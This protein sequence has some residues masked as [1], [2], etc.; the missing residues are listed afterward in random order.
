MK[1]VFMRIPNVAQDP[2]LGRYSR[3]LGDYP[4]EVDWTV[5]DVVEDFKR[6]SSLIVIACCIVAAVMAIALAVYFRGHP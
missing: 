1:R 6:E 3:V 2:E 4:P 5:A